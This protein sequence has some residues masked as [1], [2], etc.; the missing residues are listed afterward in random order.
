[1]SAIFGEHDALYC[2]RL[3]ALS[4]A[5]PRM[6]AHWGHWRVVPGAGH[7]V[8]YEAAAQFNAALMDVMGR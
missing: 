4:E 2:G 7:W 6:A 3:S 5:M 1:V 8:Q